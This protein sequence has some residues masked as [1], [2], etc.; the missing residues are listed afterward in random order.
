MLKKI[1]FL[2]LIAAVTLSCSTLNIAIDQT[3]TPRPTT[4]RPVSATLTPDSAPTATEQPTT[5]PNPPTFTNPKFYWYPIK[6][7]GCGPTYRVIFPAR[8]RRVHAMW[9][10][11]NMRSGLTIHREW[12]QDGK[13]WS[14]LDEPWDFAKYGTNGTVDDTFIY[15]FDAG[16]AP[17]NYELRVFINHQPQFGQESDKHNFTVDKNWS[18]EI[19]SPNGLLTAIIAEPDKLKLREANN[20]VWELIKTHE[21][22][23]L[24]WLPDS[25]HIVYADTEWP[26]RENCDNHNIQHTLWM[27]DA[28]TSQQFQ[29]GSSAENLH[30]PL[31]SPDGKYIA[32]ISG[33]GFGDACGIDLKLAWVEFD[34]SFQ[35]IHSFHLQDFAGIPV[36]ANNP[37]IFPASHGVWKD[38]THFEIGLDWIVC[39][40]TIHN[41]RGIYSFDLESKQATRI[42]D[43]P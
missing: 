23:D 17:G 41:P 29:I 34:S 9:D 25:K 43:L 12:Y 38:A 5:D 15:D 10:Y 16:L 35:Q 26:Q 27:V 21:I 6:H 32:A 1:L 8:V 14:Q 4:A 37:M 36:V 39:G 28:A 20:T 40:E 30:S 18:L 42:G 19:A 33:T 24:A 22:E 7:G 11:A 2:I 13:L 3:A 31:V